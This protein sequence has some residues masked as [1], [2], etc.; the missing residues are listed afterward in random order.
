MHS[1][2]IK[3][4][5]SVAGTADLQYLPQPMM[6]PFL[7]AT[8]VPTTFADAPIGVAFPP[9]SVHRE[10]VQASVGSA[11]PVVAESD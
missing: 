5:I 10:S 8:D 1:M 7:A 4:T 3:I 2:E 11:M 9:M 6:C